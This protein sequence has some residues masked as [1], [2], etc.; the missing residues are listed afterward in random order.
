MPEPLAT[1]S[2]HIHLQQNSDDDEAKNLFI[3][4]D[5]TPTQQKAE[6][7]LRDEV[8]KKKKGEKDPSVTWA[9]RNGKIISRKWTHVPEADSQTETEEDLES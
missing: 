3:H 9:I 2:F 5:L 6:K 4:P 7:A 1:A 8:K